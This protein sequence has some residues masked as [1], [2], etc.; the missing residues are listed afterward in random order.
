M[1]IRQLVLPLAAYMTGRP[2]AAPRMG[3]DAGG[4]AIAIRDLDVWAGSSSL[5]ESVNW[6]IMPNER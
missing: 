3:F 6:N 1:I 5:I 2:L 4:A